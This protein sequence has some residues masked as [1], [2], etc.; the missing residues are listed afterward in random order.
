[1]KTVL[2]ACG[3]IALLAAFA[4]PQQTHA[5][6]L[7]N[8]DLETTI[9]PDNWNMVSA[10]TTQNN[11][12]LLGWTITGGAIDVVPN[13]YWRSSTG[14]YS[15]DLAGSPGIGGISQ[16][17]TTIIGEEYQLLFDF[18]INPEN[19]TGEGSSIK[20]LAV[21]AIANDGDI[22]GIQVFS[23]DKG[24]RKYWDM[25]YETKVFLFAATSTRT[26]IAFNAMMPL[27]LPGS[28]TPLN[29]YSGPVIDNVELDLAPGTDT[30]PPPSIPEPASL[31]VLGL[32]AV[33]LLRRR[34]R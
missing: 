18:A 20:R 31:A 16:T 12:A 6:M 11:N 22:D 5:A 4:A 2:A 32:G 7:I 1:M 24:T 14:N 27:G 21:R 33:A 9:A 28:F 34:T 15:V 23:D 30:P 29:V 25:Q 10:T 17:V 26:T 3:G 13:S 8:G 19:N